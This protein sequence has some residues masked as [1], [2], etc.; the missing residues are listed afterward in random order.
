MPSVGS[1]Y[2]FAV[3]PS[4][5]S[6][7]EQ[8]VTIFDGLSLTDN[9]DTGPEMSFSM[10][11]NSAAAALVD[12]L[13]T[14]VWVY[15]TETLMYRL[16]VTAVNQDWD[17]NGDATVSVSAVG[18]KRLMNARHVQSTLTFTAADQGDIIWGLID[19]TQD[20][21]GGSWGLTQGTTTTGITRDRTYEAGENIGKVLGDLMGV[22]DGPWWDVNAAKQVIAQMP[23][24]RPT[25]ATPLVLGATCRRMGRRSASAHFTNAPYVTGDAEATVPVSMPHPDIA[26]DPRGRWE[27][28]FGFPSVVLQDT[29]VEYAEG[30]LETYAAPLTEWTV[31]IEP[32]R[33]LTDVPFRIGYHGTLVYPRSTVAP[34][35]DPVASM[36]VRTM[37]LRFGVNDNGQ[38][39]MTLSL[40]EVA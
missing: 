10:P 4:S 3:G 27:R 19:H 7:P 20:Q 17:E 1:I 21:T 28:A 16:R 23:S 32:N 24:S 18:Y 36:T 2:S 35:G 13:A 33:Y 40:L 26:T 25:I 31:D 8:E 29:L 30:A 37:G 38:I 6:T 15:Q 12:E 14:D 5:A 34:I 11:A 9:F 39:A 22:I